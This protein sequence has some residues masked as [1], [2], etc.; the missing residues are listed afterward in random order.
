MRVPSGRWPIA[1]LA[2]VLVAG[3]VGVPQ[4]LATRRDDQPFSSALRTTQS[5]TF[6]AA[7][8]RLASLDQPGVDDL[9]AIAL[10]NPDATLRRAAWDR[11]RDVQVNLVRKSLVPRIA[12]LFAG[13]AEVMR[14][15]KALGLDVTVWSA[16]DDVT[17]AAAPP[18]LIQRLGETGIGSEILYESISEWQKARDAGDA[19]AVGITPDYLAANQENL[20]QL[21]IVVIDLKNRRQPDA[22]YSDWPGDREDIL[23]RDGERVAFL[24]RFASDGT[25]ESVA[26]HV[27]LKY[28]RRGYRVEGFFTP[29]E[30]ET[31]APRLFAG[32]TFNVNRESATAD[33]VKPFLA[34]GDFHSYE[35]TLAEF[36]ALASNHPDLAKFVKLG[37]S[38][39]GR[40]I[41]ALKVSRDAEVDD[42]TKPD[43]LITGCHHAREWISVES[44]V[45]F[46]NKLVQQYSSDDSIKFL[47]DHLQ[48]WIVPIVNPDGLTYSQ[49]SAN[50]RMDLMRTWRKNRRPISLNG[51]VSSVGVDLNRNY[52]FEWR[53]SS[54]TPCSNYCSPN[55]ACLD[56][57][58]GASDDP[59]SDV[60]RGPAPASEPEVRAL[61]SLMDDPA[62]RFRAEIDYHNFGQLI[63][64][65][66]GFDRSSSD[67]A[68]TLSNLA[69]NI[70]A[71]MRTVDNQLYRPEQAIDLYPTTGSS[72][73]Y[74]YGAN[75]VAAPL[76]VEMRP[77]CCDFGVPAAQ[78]S[79]T[80]Q[81]NFAGA[82]PL[83]EWVSGPPIL[84]SVQAYSRGPDGEFSNLVYAAR[85][86][87]ST[88]GAGRE[89]I[90]DTKLAGIDPGEI[91]V[92]LQFSKPMNDSLAPRATLAHSDGDELRLV[93]V[94]SSQGWHTT[95]YPNDTWIG[96]TVLTATA[97]PGD[98][99]QLV[100][101]A[102]DQAGLQIDARPATIADYAT[103]TG[104]WLS[105][106]DSNGEGS[107][108][109]LDRNHTLAPTVG[110]DFP[111]LFVA[112]PGGGERI[113][114]G[115]PLTVSWSQP[116]I[117]TFQT[118]VQ[119]ILLSTDGGISF[120]SLMRGI[121]GS[122]EKLQLLVPNLATSHARIRI[123]AIDA[124]TGNSIY[125]DS[126]SDFTIGSDVGSAVDISFVSSERLDVNWSDVS[127]DGRVTAS[128]SRRLVINLRV[129][130]HT[131]TAVLNPFLRA[132][133][134]TRNNVVLTRDPGSP[135]GPGARQSIDAGADNVLGPGENVQVRMVIGL[136]TKKKFNLSLKAFGVPDSSGLIASSPFTVWTGKPK[137]R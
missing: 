70:S 51:C 95:K 111:S 104:N 115:D 62:R 50:D 130:N 48:I 27:N 45:Y 83:L 90:V 53:L 85:W 8:S 88:A 125:G 35:E 66:W 12:R 11:Y 124:F 49:A 84:Q 127:T 105:F 137:T 55:H 24:D 19:F 28:V 81:E 30:F 134:L 17:I 15:A 136:Q 96:Q 2:A 126:L 101:G 22:G 77:Q 135:T 80:N 46:A 33:G 23:M 10:R 114:A 69:D 129:S 110:G 119:Q 14:V 42:P 54:D 109:G 120:D 122:V 123:E 73:D 6:L 131:S 59:T 99:W 128:G 132:V 91:A 26:E 68:R 18:Y 82:W 9:W 67:D 39:E 56:D 3:A 37:S 7:L 4:I 100:V 106:E 41:F 92:Q 107:E 74:A 116:R 102:A 63:L 64:Y 34:E 103:G 79:I 121:P 71:Q 20:T 61:K 87:A 108:G 32:K 5:S 40:D 93:A 25:P 21:R 117:P 1:F 38:Y 44:P 58:L 52:P 47:M 78:I 65:P 98:F 43:V 89:L 112:S 113:S 72:T 57:D 94:G 31:Q 36:N 76:V 118:A 97:T 13:P 75:H 29:A 133:D 16:T 60:Y 86:A